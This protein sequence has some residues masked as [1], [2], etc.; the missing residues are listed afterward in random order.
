MTRMLATLVP[1]ALLVLSPVLAQDKNTVVGSGRTV[2]ET[3]ELAEFDTVELCISGDA[4]ITIGKPTP[5]EITADDNLLPL[6]KTEVQERRLVISTEYNFK[7]QHSLKI[8]ITVADLKAATVGGSGDMHI[9]GVNNE[10]LALNVNGS[11]DLDFEGKTAALAAN[12]AGSGDLKLTG[13]AEQVTASV[14]GSGH[15]HGFDLIVASAAVAI[16][17]SGD[18]RVNVAK[19]LNIQILG[20]GDVHYKGN[21]TV[22]QQIAGSGD[23]KRRD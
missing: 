15:I 17:G 21:P 4:Y 23:V 6:I 1:V 13:K 19:S 14:A 22:C 12:V 7:T 2:T 9:S 20:S 16:K 18:A 11:G 3:R 8:K 10:S 5:L